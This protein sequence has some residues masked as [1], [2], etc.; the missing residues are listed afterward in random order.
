MSMVSNNN[1]RSRRRAD[2][3][4]TQHPTNWTSPLDCCAAVCSSA[5]SRTRDT[6]NSFGKWTACSVAAK[7]WAFLHCWWYAVI[8]INICPLCKAPTLPVM[9][10][11]IWPCSLAHTDNTCVW[12]MGTE[13]W[14]GLRCNSNDGGV[15]RCT[16]LSSSYFWI[17]CTR[18]WNLFCY[19]FKKKKLVEVVALSHLHAQQ[20]M[21]FAAL[22]QVCRTKISAIAR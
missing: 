17:L 15:R 16:S 7:V 13:R 22:C 4:N 12:H 8:V 6:N 2:S 1:C 5:R 9:R 3:K 21:L 18:G 14:Y 10:V 19:S 20:P 11:A